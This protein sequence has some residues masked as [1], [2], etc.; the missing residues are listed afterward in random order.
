M[1][2][3]GDE[4]FMKFGN[5]AEACACATDYALQSRQGLVYLF[6][7]GLTIE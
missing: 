1:N 4:S 5:S 7:K 2:A 6:L 3:P